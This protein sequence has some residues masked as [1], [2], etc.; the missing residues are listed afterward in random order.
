[1]RSQPINIS[2]N[3]FKGMNLRARRGIW[4]GPK[5]VREEENDVAMISK[6]NP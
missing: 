2:I 3:E 4:R 1:M 5:E 6:K